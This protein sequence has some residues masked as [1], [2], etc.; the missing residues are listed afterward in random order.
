M[1]IVIIGAGPAGLFCGVNLAERGIECE[2]IEKKKEI[3]KPL[4]C[5][6]GVSKDTLDFLEEKIRESIKRKEVEGSVIIFPSGKK[7]YFK[8]KG[9][10][11][12][13]ELMEKLLE[14]KFLK[15]GG[16]I[17]KDE[18]IKIEKEKIYGR[19]NVYN[20]DLC[21]IATGCNFIKGIKYPY[22]NFLFA[23]EKRIRLKRKGKFFEFYHGE[24]YRPVYLWKFSH[25]DFTGIGKSYRDKKDLEILMEMVN[26][27]KKLKT[28]TG[29]IPYPL[30]PPEFL[31]RDKKIFIGDAGAFIHQLTFAGIHGAFLSAILC[32]ERINKFLKK[33]RESEL[34]KFNDLLKSLF[35]F[36]KSLYRARNILYTAS[37]RELNLIGELMDGRNYKDIP[38]GRAIKN[39][40]KK[41][42]IINSYIKFLWIKKIY[43]LSENLSF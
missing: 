5:A 29:K 7:I 16:R 22:R 25:K 9:F 36:R 33:G 26:K 11:I 35:Y 13:R 39:L 41:P 28:I 18:V 14:K 37:D 34:E 42:S 6:E 19:K 38:Y 31:Y 15:L 32:S 12:D 8:R 23:T 17:I 21:I 24:K 4:K 43:E 10:L 1:K 30:K 20:A 40:F 2:I 3:G 27:E